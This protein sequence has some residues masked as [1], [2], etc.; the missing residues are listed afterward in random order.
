[1]I[2]DY[3]VFSRACATNVYRCEASG[4]SYYL[5]TKDAAQVALSVEQRQK[6]QNAGCTD[7][8]QFL[9]YTFDTHWRKVGTTIR[10]GMESVPLDCRW[11]SEDLG[12]YQAL[13]YVEVTAFYV[14]V[15]ILN[16]EVDFELVN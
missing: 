6:C 15:G 11:Y 2:L 14:M 5:D 4:Y 7:G 16:G 10:S 9:G 1:M 8:G 3:H 12:K 13:F